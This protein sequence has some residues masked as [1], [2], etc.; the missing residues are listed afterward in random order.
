MKW[1]AVFLLQVLCCYAVVIRPRSLQDGPAADAPARKG[2]GPFGID[3]TILQGFDL[4]R[5]GPLFASIQ[6]YFKTVTESGLLSNIAGVFIPTLPLKNRVI[7]QAE[8]RKSAKRVK[9]RLGPLTLVGKGVRVNSASLNQLLIVESKKNLQSSRQ[10]A[11][12]H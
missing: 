2:L 4:A 10:G 9:S 11:F 3:L 5:F 8:I 6:P 7:L 12:F 1:N